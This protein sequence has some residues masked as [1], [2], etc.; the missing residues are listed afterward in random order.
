ME[1]EEKLYQIKDSE[2]EFKVDPNATSLD[3]EG[4]SIYGSTPPKLYHPTIAGTESDIAKFT[5]AIGYTNVPELLADKPE[6]GTTSG[7]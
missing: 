7:T 6:D 1:G 5:E 3:V 4:N 2:L